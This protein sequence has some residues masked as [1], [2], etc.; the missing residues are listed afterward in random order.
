MTVESSTQDVT[1]DTDGVTL[2]YAVPF[3]FLDSAHVFADFV[4]ASEAITSLTNGIDFTVSG[5]GDEEGG[6]LTLAATKATGYKLHI[7][8]IVPVTQ[9]T[10]YQQNSAFP[11]KTTETALDKLTMIAQQ[12]ASGV[13]NSIRYPLAEYG[14]D[15]TLPYASERAGNV[16]GFD[17]AGRQTLLPIP[18]SVGAG[19][20]RTDTFRASNGDF[21]AGSTTSLTL[22]RD[23]GSAD[24]VFVWWDGVPQ[25][26]FSLDGKTL[27]FTEAIYPGTSVVR[28]RTGTTLSLEV[29]S[30]ESVGDEELQWGGG[31]QR[32]FSSIASLRAT[33][34]SRYQVAFVTGYYAPRD[35]G[36]GPYVV[37]PSDTTSADNGGSIIVDGLNRR[38][39]L[40]TPPDWY[41]EQFGARGNGSA[42]DAAAI[43]AAIAALPTW[44]GTV[45]FQGKQYNIGSTIVVGTGDGGA[46][47]STKNGIRLIGTGG[48]YGIVD[49][50]P[51]ILQVSATINNPAMLVIGAISDVVIESLCIYCSLKATI[52]LQLVAACGTQLRNVTLRQYTYAGL[53][54]HGGNAPTGNYN[55][56]NE[57]HN[58]DATSTANGHRGLVM[59]GNYSAINDTWLT[60]FYNCR[61]DTTTSINSIAAYFAFSDSC[62]F[63]RCHFVGNNTGGVPL[64]GCYG[65][66]FDAVNNPGY[67][68]GHVFHDCS[69][70]ST[71]VNEAAGAQIGY[72]SF[73]NYGV[74]DNENLPTHAKL[75]GFTSHG[76]PFNGWGT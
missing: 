16:L 53:Y 50:P 52:A 5:A 72:M 60:T 30:A 47:K 26:D 74:D 63:H 29:P 64:T 32:C 73:I 43:N 71:W 42:D 11:A 14:T 25:F 1:Y 66:Y 21:V 10:S 48:G 19:D 61:F 54:F 36:G 51:T 3:Y 7:Y 6:T 65:L 40:N 55:I 56:H 46:N 22:S 35:G 76:T 34:D 39:K 69:I 58:V 49:R 41:V 15:G 18:A 75:R 17:D 67:P 13:E 68:S 12:Q 27:T 9:E 44:G 57:V 59:D 8:R 70:L 24:N 31:L 20:L 23:P 45:R 4:S 28:V 38:W 2:Q 37:D 33:A 62:S